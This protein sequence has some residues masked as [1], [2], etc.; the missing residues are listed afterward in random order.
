MVGPCHRALFLQPNFQILHA[1]WAE[2]TPPKTVNP[3][4]PPRWPSSE[5]PDLTKPAAPPSPPSPFLV[6]GKLLTSDLQHLGCSRW[7]GQ[8]LREGRATARKSGNELY[9]D[10]VLWDGARS[11]GEKQ[12]TH[13]SHSVWFL[14]AA[15]P[16]TD[17]KRK[18]NMDQKAKVEFSLRWYVAVPAGPNVAS[19]LCISCVSASAMTL[20]YSC[21]W[22]W[23]KWKIKAAEDGETTSLSSGSN[24]YDTLLDN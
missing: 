3:S 13:C 16:R 10:K 17:E 15:E 2:A 11:R 21:L 23:L 14:K 6:I 18:W 24:C 1:I 7:T 8:Q 9:W 22:I 4:L 5:K 20:S 12:I 19:S